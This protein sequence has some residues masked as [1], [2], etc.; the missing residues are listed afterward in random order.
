MNKCTNCNL[1]VYDK[2]ETCPLCHK[3]LDETG[4]ADR[5]ITE[6]FISGL[7]GY[8]DVRTRERKIV[9]LLKIMLF[10][11]VVAEIISVVINYLTTPHFWWS[12][13]SG[14]SALYLYISMYYW[15]K[16]DSG[17][18]IK[19][20]VQLLQTMVLL[21]IIDY[22]TGWKGWALTWAVPGLILLGDAIVFFF[23]MLYKNNWYSYIML[24]VLFAVLSVVVILLHIPGFTNH[25]ILAVICTVITGLY[26]LGTIIFGNMEF[27]QEMRRRFHV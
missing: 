18:A 21:V 13:I 20:G 7:S 19:I 9:F 10:A 3:M 22:Y 5:E 26:L 2:R 6:R 14:I 15:V 23:M 24:I 27:G 16:H 17:L 11:I 1:I 25:I 4:E 12:A 8:P